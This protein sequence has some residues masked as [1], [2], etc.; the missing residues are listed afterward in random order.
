LT[1]V[2][3]ESQYLKPRPIFVSNIK[4]FFSADS[5]YESFKVSFDY[6]VPLVLG[7][8]LFQ[9]RINEVAAQHLEMERYLDHQD[10]DAKKKVFDKVRQSIIRFPFVLTPS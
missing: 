3:D 1:D 8:I 10:E 9:K 6:F 4:A 2:E 7:L 5:D